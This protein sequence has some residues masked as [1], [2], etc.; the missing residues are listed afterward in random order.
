MRNKIISIVSMIAF[1]L[2]FVISPIARADESK[3]KLRYEAVSPL[4]KGDH[5]PFTGILFSKDLAAR[6]EAERKTMIA[7]KLCDAKL[8]ASVLLAKSELQLKV[9]I[10]TGKYSALQTKHNDIIAVKDGQIEFLR[11]NHMPTPWYESPAFLITVGVLTGI[12]LSLG[13]AHLV[14]TVR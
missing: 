4:S 2:A 14:K 6:I 9:D 1:T 5:A 11:E 10:L 13:A 12:G 7:I 8:N 3:L